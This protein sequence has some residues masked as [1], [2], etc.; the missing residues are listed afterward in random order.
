MTTKEL[1]LLTVIGLLTGVCFS[2]T[3][4]TIAQSQL[5][6]LQQ[7]VVDLQERRIEQ[8]KTICP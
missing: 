5:I 2:L 4:R 7:D 3:M 1:L 8:L 6:E